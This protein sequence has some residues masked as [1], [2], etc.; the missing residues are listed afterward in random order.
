MASLTGPQSVSQN[1]SSPSP[2]LASC[3]RLVG[4]CRGRFSPPVGRVVGHRQDDAD[5]RDA[6]GDAVVEAHDQ[7]LAADRG[8]DQTEVPQRPVGIERLRG[9]VGQIMLQLGLAAR[10]GQQFAVKVAVEI[11]IGIVLP[12]I[13][14]PVGHHQLAKAAELQHA[15]LDSGAQSPVIELPL[16]KHDADD[17]HQ[18]GRPIHA[19]PGSIDAGHAFARRHDELRGQTKS[20]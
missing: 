20:L 8:I 2:S 15:L 16:E 6:V 5:H 17:L 3:V 10:G 9:E 18:I 4:R 19:Q 11:E 7:G 14:G 1:G 12:D 13:A